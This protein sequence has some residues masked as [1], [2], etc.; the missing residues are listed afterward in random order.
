MGGLSAQAGG[1]STNVKICNNYRKCDM[2]KFSCD[3]VP[4]VP[5]SPRGGRH[6]TLKLLSEI[7]ATRNWTVQSRKCVCTHEVHTIERVKGGEMKRWWRHMCRQPSSNKSYRPYVVRS[8]RNPVAG[9]LPP[10]AGRGNPK[11]QNSPPMI[12]HIWGTLV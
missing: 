12:K 8:N 1:K 10:T 7:H 9:S 4:T 6:I 11:T 3:R 5:K 2:S